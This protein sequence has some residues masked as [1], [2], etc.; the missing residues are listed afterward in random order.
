MNEE[1]IGTNYDFSCPINASLRA[2]LTVFE[3]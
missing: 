3:N 2:E 1:V